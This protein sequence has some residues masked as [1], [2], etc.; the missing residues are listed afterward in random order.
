MKLSGRLAIGFLKAG[1]PGRRLGR[2]AGLAA[3][4][5]LMRDR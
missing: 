1:T 2:L 5:Q 4:L 3:S